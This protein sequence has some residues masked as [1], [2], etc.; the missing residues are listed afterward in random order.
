MA[1]PTTPASTANVDNGS[2]N[3]GLA[4]ADIKQN[5]D[6]VNAIIDEFGEVAITTPANGEALVYDG[7][8]SRWINSGA[9]GTRAAYLTFS[10][11]TMSISND[12]YSIVN[13]VS[14]VDMN[15][16]A[17]TY[18]A[19]ITGIFSA[20]HNNPDPE[21]NLETLKLRNNTAGADIDNIAYAQIMHTDNDEHR[22][23]SISSANSFTLTTTSDVRVTFT[24]DI[25]SD[26]SV[27]FNIS[28]KLFR[29]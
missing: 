26:G 10:A 18:K 14:G 4:R 21:P 15:L 20:Q 6:N 23:Y 24:T 28:I 16:A 13:S 1:W 9:A 25:I 22:V 8:N 11:N 17:G 19:I 29:V 5:I 27:S 12:E 7:S 2:D 3:P